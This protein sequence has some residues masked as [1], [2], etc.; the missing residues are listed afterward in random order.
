MRGTGTGE[1]N[2]AL[3]KVLTHVYSK[4]NRS[5]LALCK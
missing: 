4:Q 5:D 1:T 3:E 2:G